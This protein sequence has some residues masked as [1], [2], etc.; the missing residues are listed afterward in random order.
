MN[1]GEY[2]V[3]CRDGSVRICELYAAFLA[4]RLI[5]TFNDITERKLAEMANRQA[6]ENLRQSEARY[7]LLAE[8][9]KD[10]VWL[11]DMDL[12]TIYISPSVEKLRGYTME[13]LHQLTLDRQVASA[14]F[15]LAKKAFSE[16]LS[17]AAADPAYNINRTLELEFY[18]KDG[19]TYWSETTYSL[20]RDKDGNPI[21]ILG[22][23]R[24]ITERKR[25]EEELQKSEERFRSLYENSTDRP[26]QDYS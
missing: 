24:N 26:L 10:T 14:S 12:R 19:T 2:R 25:A 17:K 7:R 15:Q 16:E 1:T 3:T 23:G 4:E 22:E 6:E 11:M 20:I 18:R 8:H 5:V 13:E 21:S 9:M